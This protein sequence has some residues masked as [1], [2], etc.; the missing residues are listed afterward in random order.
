MSGMR[1]WSLVVQTLLLLG[2]LGVMFLC[3]TCSW[4]PTPQVITV[5]PPSPQ[6]TDTP[7]AGPAPT[8]T[9]LAEAPTDVPTVA[10][11]TAVEALSASSAVGSASG[12]MLSGANGPAGPSVH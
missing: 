1:S 10:V 7:P 8:D 11:M 5:A 6:P 3:G 9:P 12:M 4:L 2:G